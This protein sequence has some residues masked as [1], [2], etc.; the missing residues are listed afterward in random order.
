MRVLDVAC[1]PGDVSI[2]A[3]HLVGPAGSVTGVDAQAS[4]LDLAAQRAAGA[5]L[6]NVTFR[7]ATPRSR[8]W[9]GPDRSTRSS[10]A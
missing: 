7:H 9:T 3:A 1:G 4:I 8:S 10:A 5:G 6:S 2:A